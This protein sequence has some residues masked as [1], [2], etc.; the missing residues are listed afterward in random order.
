VKKKSIGAD[1]HPI[2]QQSAEATVR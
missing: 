2:V 1:S